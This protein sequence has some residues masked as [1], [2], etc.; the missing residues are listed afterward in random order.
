MILR[1]A[2]AGFKEA[3]KPLY[4]GFCFHELQLNLKVCSLAGNDQSCTAA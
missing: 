4:S 3:A 1:A 2:L